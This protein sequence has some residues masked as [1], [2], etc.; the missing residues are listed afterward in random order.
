MVQAAR[1]GKQNIVEGSMAAATSKETEI[2]LTNV[3]RAS[4]E[5]LL[6]DYRDFLRTRGLEE[7]PK[8]HAY[9]LRLRMAA[10][11]LQ[12]RREGR[13]GHVVLRD[14]ELHRVVG[15]ARREH[16]SWNVLALE[17]NRAVASS[18]ISLSAVRPDT[19]AP[20]THTRNLLASMLLASRF[21]QPPRVPAG[22]SP[23]NPRSISR[24]QAVDRPR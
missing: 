3:A 4:L 11:L 7:W 14:R 22:N 2:K 12:R 8:E 9:A 5:E 19:P 18:R 1:S 15:H 6:V 17:A 23:Q 13:V 21:G 16:P 10:L 24:C 20:T